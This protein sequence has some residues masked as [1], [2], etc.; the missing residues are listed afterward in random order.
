MSRSTTAAATIAPGRVSPRGSKPRSTDVPSRS[1]IGSLI[2]VMSRVWVSAGRRSGH[3]WGSGAGI[4]SLAAGFAAAGAGRVIGVL[5]VCWPSGRSPSGGGGERSDPGE[6]ADEVVLPGPAGWEAQRPLA[7]AEG[8]PPGDL[9]Q[10]AAQGAR[11]ADGLA[12]QADQAAPA[13]QVVRQAADHRPGAV[14][15]EPARREVRERLVFEVADGEL[16]DGV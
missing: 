4:G 13:Q 6:R 5:D 2:G 1:A 8:Q 10:P 14:R 15:V 3:R 11:S 9:E 12:G 16:D 7:G